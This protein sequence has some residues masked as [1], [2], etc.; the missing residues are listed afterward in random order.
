VRQELVAV[1]IQPMGNWKN[2]HS[3]NLPDVKQE[4][5]AVLVQPMGNWKI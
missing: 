3:P 4:I 2:N 5:A 1:L